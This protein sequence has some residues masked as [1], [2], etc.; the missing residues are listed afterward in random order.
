[1]E[2][3]QEIG[4]DDIINVLI[5]RWK[6]ILIPSILAAMIAVVY[7]KSL[8]KV[9]DSYA[10]LKLGYLGE[11]QFETVAVI[12]EI[13][14]SLPMRVEIASKIKDSNN[15][16]LVDFLKS[17]ITYE[18]ASGL[19]KIKAINKTPEKA[20]DIVNAVTDIV[21][22]RHKNMYEDAQKKLYGTMEKI[23]DFVRP[24]PLTTGIAEFKIEPTKV[25]IPAITNPVPVD[26]KNKIIVLTV[27]FTVMLFNILIAFY[28]EGKEKIK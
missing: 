23:R 5:K 15:P 25:E 3:E 22:S 6:L 19:L 26:G 28:L 17:A 2:E 24:I 9:Y 12:K 21:S 7:V 16:K 11:K 8:P 20:A 13:M 4:I 27:F 10:L 1:M 14:S 18:D